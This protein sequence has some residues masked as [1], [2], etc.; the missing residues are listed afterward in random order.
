[1]SDLFKNERDRS[2]FYIAL[3]VIGFFMWL[4]GFSGLFG[5]KR[6]LNILQPKT[7]K[8][9]I[10]K[11]TKDEPV[12]IKETKTVIVPPTVEA[13]KHTNIIEEE[14]ILDTDNDG[15]ADDVDECPEVK[16]SIS[17]NGCPDNDGD[18]VVDKDDNCPGIVGLVALNG[19]PDSDGDGISDKMDRCPERA[20]TKANNGCP[21]IKKEVFERIN[22]AGKSI[23]FH[24]AS[25]NIK[26]SSYVSL[27]KIV[28]EIKNHPAV[29]VTIEGHTDATGNA[30]ANLTL[31]QERADAVRAYLLKQGLKNNVTAQGF[32][33]TKPV[34]TNKTKAGRY[35]NRRVEIKLNY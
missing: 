17:T 31:S 13:V 28:S 10:T 2:D 34:A 20:G 1:M 7:V 21:E 5:K 29:N 4:F 27:N 16:G 14:V 24:S 30:D 35:Q 6:H 25:S 22:L 32:G 23:Q 3:F 11:I 9:Q 8:T 33:Q 12:V 26:R 18:G 19:C 15:V